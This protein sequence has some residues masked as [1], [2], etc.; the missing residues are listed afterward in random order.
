MTRNPSP[1]AFLLILAGLV[2]ACATTGDH[3]AGPRVTVDNQTDYVVAVYLNERTGQRPVASA[4]AHA[5]STLR[6]EDT[7]TATLMLYFRERGAGPIVQS[8]RAVVATDAALDIV[9]TV[10]PDLTV[11]A[12]VG[13]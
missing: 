4:E 7:G 2:S 9:L 8:R 11:L 1:G 6:L 10:E 12:T 5:R 13:A 3:A